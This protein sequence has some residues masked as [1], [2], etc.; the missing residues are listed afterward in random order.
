MH[1]QLSGEVESNAATKMILKNKERMRTS[2]KQMHIDNEI[3]LAIQKRIRD[4]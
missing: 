3:S 2:N 1:P 4:E